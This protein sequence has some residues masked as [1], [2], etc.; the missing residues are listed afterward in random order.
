MNR[1]TRLAV[2]VGCL[3][4]PPLGALGLSAV[5][6]AVATS[7]DALILVA[8]VIVVAVLADRLSGYLA[9]VSSA[10]WFDFFL[11]RPYDRFAID[12]RPD[13]ETFVA[14]LVVGVGVTELAEWS[15]R[16]RR[17][18]DVSARLMAAVA[19]GAALGASGESARAVVDRSEELLVEVLELRACRY[20]PGDLEPPRARLLASGE[21][22]NAGLLWPVEEW[23]LPGPELEIAVTWRGRVRGRFVLTPRAAHPVARERRIAAVALA[24]SVAGSL[25][26]AGVRGGP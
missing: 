23:G 8:F 12:H 3:V 4:L 14:L 16:S 18:H 6:H 15:R 13:I 25:P 21:V 9:T 22:E 5:R 24:E 19:E 26:S 11:T 7:A 2:A 1:R 17:R 10:A 20:E